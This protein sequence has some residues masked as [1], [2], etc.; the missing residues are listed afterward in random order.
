MRTRKSFVLVIM[1]VLISSVISSYAYFTLTIT[2]NESAKDIVVTMGTLELTFIDG[3]EVVATN[4]YPGDA[5]NKTLY[6][7]NTGTLDTKY[8]LILNEYT[9]EFLNEEIV[10]SATCVVRDNASS[11]VIGECDGIELLS[12][13][14]NSHYLTDGVGIISGQTHEYNINIKFIDTNKDQNYNQNKSFSTKINV[15]EY[16]YKMFDKCNSESK[17][18][19]CVM[20]RDNKVINDKD[21]DYIT[22]GGEG[23]YFI[24]EINY[25]DENNDGNINP[26]YFY[27]GNVLNNYVK[28]NNMLF[29]IIRTTDSG[30]IKLMY[31]S[32][33]DSEFNSMYSDNAGIGY[34]YGSVNSNDYSLVHSNT[35]DSVAKKNLEGFFKNN[36]SSLISSDNYGNDS[37]YCNDRS[38]Y[39]GKGFADEVTYYEGYNRVNNKLHPTLE[40]KNVTDR[41][42]KSENIN[43][44]VGLLTLDEVIYS[45]VTYEGKGES[46]L[47]NYGKLGLMT[48]SYYSGSKV[49]LYGLNDGISLYSHCDGF[50]LYPVISISND[51]TV[52]TGGNGL[53]DS[54]YILSF[55]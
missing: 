8:S 13:N 32:G 26:I 25:I 41:F 16:T 20:L 15:V 10:L 35:N 1:F 52:I 12:L 31:T 38:I 36:L 44:P 45:G 4:I 11:E 9:N 53:I 3:D 39:E 49:Y 29:R 22:G 2:G 47:N 18:L 28:L 43:Y 34:M 24:N 37:I 23:L 7:K 42:S 51:N 30:D 55:K 48:P 33:I 54:P 50:K 21:V 17:D 40:C 19:A 14:E 27:R 46:F 6:V 5:I